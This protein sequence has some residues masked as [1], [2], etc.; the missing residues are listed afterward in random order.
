MGVPPAGGPPN[1]L[2][3]V[4]SQTPSYSSYTLW[5]ST[6]FASRSK[7]PFFNFRIS[8]IPF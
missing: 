8:C 5:V 6:F 3:L 1:Y 2:R 7:G 4:V